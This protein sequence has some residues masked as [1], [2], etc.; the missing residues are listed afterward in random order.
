M[1]G[2]MM[3]LLFITENLFPDV[4]GGSGRVVQEFGLSLVRLGHDVTILTRRRSGLPAI[5]E[6]QG[7][8]VVRYA[9]EHPLHMCRTIATCLKKCTPECGFDA[10]L[11][12]QPLPG[13]AA[14][15][16]GQLKHT[17]VLREFHGPWH[18]EFRVKIGGARLQTALG[19]FLRKKIDRFTLHH[20]SK[21]RVLSEYMKEEVLRIDPRLQD[22]IIVI[23]GGV[24][25]DRFFPAASKEAV[26]AQLHIPADRLLLFTIRN[27]TPRMGIQNLIPAIE[28]IVKTHP[29]VLVHIGGSGPQR[30]PLLR[31]IEKLGLTDHVQLLGRIS[32]E[33]LKLYYQAADLF[34][35]PTRDLEGFGLVTLE[36]MA[37]GAAVLATPQGGTAEIVRG[38]EDIFL[39]RDATEE[40]M[41]EKIGEL[42]SQ[43]LQ[44]EKNRQ[45]ARKVARHFS[46]Q[47]QTKRMIEE[48]RECAD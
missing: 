42:L 44:L 38:Y 5:E 48:V 4:M 11:I 12:E 1:F 7:M 27:L 9:C 13:L 29:T 23:P 40:A 41:A 8:H 24:N 43:P 21:I 6:V 25:P 33:D 36:A 17:A 47:A 46:W 34:V 18:E 20:A 28:K 19:I 26:R 14:L 30:R 37:S 45:T 3:K 2:E 10:V 39:F 31:M 15:L 22:K 35:L 32:D 16:S